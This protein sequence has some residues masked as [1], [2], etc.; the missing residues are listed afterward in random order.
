M[1]AARMPDFAGVDGLDAT[2]FRVS[3]SGLQ[4][5]EIHV[6][7]AR[8]PQLH[9]VLCEHNGAAE[10]HAL[11]HFGSAAL[12]MLR[13][14]QGFKV[15]AD[16]DLAHYLE[17]GIG[18]FVAKK[19]MFAGRVTGGSEAEQAAREKQ[20][21]LFEVDAAG[22]GFEWSVPGD[23][24]IVRKR[25]GAVVGYVTSS[26]PGATSQGRTI[27]LGYVSLRETKQMVAWVDEEEEEGAAGEQEELVAEAYGHAWPT[28]VLREPPA[29]MAGRD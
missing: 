10:A 14:E 7:A 19:R 2:A 26:A 16:M 12:N 24:P 23:T 9:D 5:Y 3:F 15:R 28:R 29:R 6:P 22:S 20:A 4:G 8:G 18:T 13:V 27:A 17:G 21:V 25:D 11:R 1:H